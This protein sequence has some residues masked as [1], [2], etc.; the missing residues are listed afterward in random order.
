MISHLFKMMW[1]R[2]KNNSLLIVEFFACFLVL[3]VA[4]YMATEMMRHYFKPVNY[5]YQHVYHFSVKWTNT[6]ENQVRGILR[7]MKGELE[8]WPEIEK[9]SL[10]ANTVPFLEAGNRDEQVEYEGIVSKAQRW[11]A[12]ENFCKLLR[13]P[14]LAGKWYSGGEFAHMHPP[15][16]ITRAMQEEF[17]GTANPLGKRIKVGEKEYSVIGIINN[18]NVGKWT[19]SQSGYF[20]LANLHTEKTIPRH[21]L[22]KFEKDLTA[23]EYTKLNTFISGVKKNSKLTLQEGGTLEL[24]RKLDQG[25]SILPVV[26]ISVV[27]G[28]L[29][30]NVIVGLFGILW[31]SIRFRRA[32]IGLRRAIGADA[33]DIYFQ[34]LGEVV[35]LATFGIIPSALLAFHF[36]LLHFLGFEMKQSIYVMLFAALIIYVLVILCALYPSKLAASISPADALHEN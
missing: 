4:L 22:I 16:V 14:A 28:F 31:Q 29:I 21:F 32:E 26:L 18:F 36:P 30:I 3:F 15:I 35:I 13:I 17:F 6:P 25:Q 9:I 10:T 24:Y 8:M 12:D 23:H 33:G 27:C 19:Y 2:R 5:S 20:T 7:R 34:L 11:E 1:N